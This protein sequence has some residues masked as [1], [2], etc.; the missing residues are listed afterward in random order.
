[1][2]LVTRWSMSRTVRFL[3][4]L[5]VTAMAAL[6]A[7]A[8]EREEGLTLRSR[9][10]NLV[11]RPGGLRSN[12]VA[13]RTVASS[14]DLRQR[15]EELLAAA[16]SVD[17]AIVGYF[18]RL[19]LSAR[20]TRLSPIDA[21]SIGNVL[22]APPSTPTYEQ[23][24]APLPAGTPVLNHAVTFPVLL[25][26]TTFQLSLQV[27]LLD[28]VL[29]I[30]G[31]SQG[32]KHQREATRWSE[33]AAQLQ[34]AADARVLYY[35]WAH[36]RLQVTVADQALVQAKSHLDSAH[37]AF[38]A[39]SANKADVMR[40]EAQVASADLFVVRARNLEA[41]LAEQ[42]RTVMHDER[43]GGYEIGE[44][45]RADLAAQS[46]PALAALVDEA[47]KTRAEV[48][49]LDESGYAQASAAKTAKAGYLPHLDA[50]GDV[51]SANPNQRYFPQH[52]RFDT[53]W[54][55]GVQL[56]YSP[57]EI[58]AAHFAARNADAKTRAIEAQ[59]GG[60]HDRLRV[61]VM[62]SLEA[63]REAEFA[64]QSTARGLDAAEE[65][66]RVRRDLYA[67]GRSTSIELTDAETDVTQS[68]L[69][70]IGARIDQ[71]VARIRLLH[72]IGRDAE[73]ARD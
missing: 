27:P 41:V 33:R 34:V 57:N 65:S 2:S 22:V 44:D 7:G 23:T 15:R 13:E 70:A 31:L 59:I 25:N 66:Y 16:A 37:H 64:V 10:N 40:V 67:V 53:T 35:Q 45:L 30:P 19:G 38:D 47:W 54:D 62:Q 43:G 61:E 24:G 49:V 6:P 14:F 32:A 12:E 18:P 29:R 42:L 69:N 28:Y 26:Q 56:T 55:V 68:R 36:A 3:A 58:A 5:W 39:G 11:A 21:Q 50:F 17:Q 9:L 71:R 8:R 20:Y 73:I 60:L 4:V 51:T 72:A 63:L 48:H 1:L 46:L 52:D